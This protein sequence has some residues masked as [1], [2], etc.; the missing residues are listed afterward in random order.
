MGVTGR[1]QPDNSQERLLVQIQR[2]AR[3]AKRLD[4]L[5]GWF[6]KTRWGLR[7]VHAQQSN[8]VREQSG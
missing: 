7:Q 6:P 2:G 8:S 5:V 4:N 3:N 1:L